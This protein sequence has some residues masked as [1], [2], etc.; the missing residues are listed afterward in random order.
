MVKKQFKFFKD[1]RISKLLYSILMNKRRGYL[2]IWFVKTNEVLLPSN[3]SSIRTGESHVPSVFWTSLLHKPSP[4]I[5][6]LA[7]QSK[8]K[9]NVN[10]TKPKSAYSN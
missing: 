3:I 9:E 4:Q 6:F 5:S 2:K 1:M 7:E 8:V 10:F